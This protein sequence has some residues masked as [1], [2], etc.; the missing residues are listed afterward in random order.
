M[1][2]LIEDTLSGNLKSQAYANI[3]DDDMDELDL[4]LS[5]L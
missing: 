3:I 5:L 2:F 1:H 4:T